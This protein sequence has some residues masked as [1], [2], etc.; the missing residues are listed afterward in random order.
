MPWMVNSG[1]VNMPEATAAA[2]RNG[3][4]HTGDQLVV[5]ENGEFLFVDRVK[6]AIRRRGENISSY[7]VEVEVLSHPDVDQAAAVG[8]AN[9]DLEEE[10]SEQEVKVVL[11]PV[12]GREIDPRELTEYLIPRM[13][14]HMVPRYIEVVPELP[15]TPSFKIKKAELR[16]AG[17][18]PAT[19]DREAAGIKLRR[20]S[21]A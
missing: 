20:E 17:I 3:W 12:E 2:W 14:R 19:W 21:F 9:P 18:T 15:R 6:D 10:T 11:V 13:P 7:E 4:F 16:E 1:Y 5:D 8:I